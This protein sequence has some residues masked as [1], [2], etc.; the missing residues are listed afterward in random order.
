MRVESRDAAIVVSDAA[1]DAL[2]PVF[3]DVFFLFFVPTAATLKI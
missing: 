1:A 3:A 2:V